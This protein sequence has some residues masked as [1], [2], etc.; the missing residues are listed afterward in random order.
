MRCGPG[1]GLHL[2]AHGDEQPAAPLD[3]GLEPGRL[4]RDRGRDVGAAPPRRSPSSDSRSPAVASFTTGRTGE[5]GAVS[6]ASRKNTSS[7]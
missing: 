7:R 6:A 5:L 4:L 3:E 1:L 2:V